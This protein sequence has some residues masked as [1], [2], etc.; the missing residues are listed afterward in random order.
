MGE[1]PLELAAAA[2]SALR[3]SVS[4]RL[5]TQLFSWGSTL[6]VIRLLAPA[7]YGLM[8]MA[9]VFIS[10][11]AIFNELG[12]TAFIV[13]AASISKEELG[14]V[15]CLLLLFNG[16]LVALIYLAAP[17]IA[18]L[19]QAEITWIVRAC[20]LVLIARCFGVIQEA[21]LIRRL[22]F[23]RRSI[24]EASSLIVGSLLTLAL[25]FAGYGVWA[26]V[27]G[28]IATA[29]VKAVALTLGARVA[30]SLHFRL[31]D[32]RPHIGYSTALLIQRLLWWFY[33]QADLFFLGL[34]RGASALGIYSVG[35]DLAFMP[36]NKLGSVLNQLGFATY[37]KC[38]E[39]REQLRRVMLKAL[40]YLAFISFIYASLAAALAPD[41]VWWVLGERWAASAIVFQLISLAVPF[42]MLNIQFAEALNAVGEPGV[43]LGTLA[44]NAVFIVGCVVAGS[45]WGVAGAA[46]GWAVALPVA[47]MV[48][49]RRAAP[50]TLIGVADLLAVIGRPLVIGLAVL[51][52]VGFG[53]LAI[54]SATPSLGSTASLIAIAI[55][56]LGLG[57]AVLQRARLF[58][59]MAFILKKPAASTDQA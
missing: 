28:T 48:A 16:T 55:T 49:A 11:S 23:R 7:D 38:Q 25:A 22:D 45:F 4:A 15:F 43:A 44:L 10:F 56:T 59:I 24:I 52:A 20:G 46:A 9:M 36:T 39:D 6:V 18:A 53:R 5:V 33:M 19:Y 54:D 1:R 29:S 21:I 34:V 57:I 51:A 3:W 27:W 30:Y 12:A 40:G 32:I 13:R 35:R 41:L 50:V 17:L 42:V 2:A 47:C 14:S 31:A 37:A 58:E 26:L 8:A